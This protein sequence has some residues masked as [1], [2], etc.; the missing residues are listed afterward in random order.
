MDIARV[1]VLEL[2]TQLLFAERLQ[3]LPASEFSALKPLLMHVNCL[4]TLYRIYL[5]FVISDFA[6]H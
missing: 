2:G 4:L 5:S 1:S 3:L 6:L